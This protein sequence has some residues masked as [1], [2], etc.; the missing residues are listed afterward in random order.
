MEVDVLPAR[1]GRATRRRG[2]GDARR[3][4]HVPQ[5]LLLEECSP[6]PSNPCCGRTNKHRHALPSSPFR[7]TLP[8]A[9]RVSWRCDRRSSVNRCCPQPTSLGEYRSAARSHASADS[10]LA[11]LGFRCARTVASPVQTLSMRTCT[12]GR[13]CALTRAR[14]HARTHVAFLHAPRHKQARPQAQ[15]SNAVQR[16]HALRTLLA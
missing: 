13:T 1:S 6:P 5:V 7:R 9:P 12:H 16:T 15:T 2:E 3:L 11:H 4:V 14:T 10:S 8:P